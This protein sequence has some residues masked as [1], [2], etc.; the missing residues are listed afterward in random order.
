[1]FVSHPLL[2]QRFL[3]T[4]LNQCVIEGLKVMAQAEGVAETPSKIIIDLILVV[5]DKVAPRPRLPGDFSELRTIYY[6][7]VEHI[8]KNEGK[9]QSFMRRICPL[10]EEIVKG[11][12]AFVVTSCHHLYCKGCFDKL[13]DQNE[14]ADTAIRVCKSCNQ[15]I[16]EAGYSDDSPKDSP[17][18]G[19]PK[20]GS[21]KKG[22]PKKRKQSTPKKTGKEPFKKRS[23]KAIS[24]QVLLR[25]PSDD[26]WDEPSEDEVDWV[27]RIGDRMLSAKTTAVRDLVSNWLKEDENVK[28]VIFVQ[29]LKTIRLLQFMCEEECWEYAT[30]RQCWERKTPSYITNTVNID[31]REGISHLAR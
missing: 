27:S 14:N 13:P 18:K 25:D 12:E 22:S 1:M 19:S 3:E 8:R 26:E 7:Y 21:P 29:F 31:Y 5:A 9:Y 10:C 23:Q 6:E 24:Q 4:V 11:E 30:V 2:T 17:K 15:P 16:E 20:K 28:I